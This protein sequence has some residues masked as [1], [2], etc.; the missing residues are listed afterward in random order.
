MGR[1]AEVL[2][3]GGM[4]KEAAVEWRW[5]KHMQALLAWFRSLFGRRGGGWA[6]Q[7]EKYWKPLSSRDPGRRLAFRAREPGDITAREELTKEYGGAPQLAN[8]VRAAEA[9]RRATGIVPMQ[10]LRSLDR[11]IRSRELGR[12]K[13]F[14]AK[15]VGIGGYYKPDEETLTTTRQARQFS[16]VVPHELRHAMQNTP[17]VKQTPE[18]YQPL[19]GG[20]KLEISEAQLQADPGD[21]KNMTLS[22]NERDYQGIPDR[23]RG[24]IT[25]ATLNVPNRAVGMQHERVLKYLASGKE[26]EAYLGNARAWGAAQGM[27]V[28]ADPRRGRQEARRVLESMMQAKPA[29]MPWL[30]ALRALDPSSRDAALDELSNMMPA[31][32]QAVPA[33]DYGKYASLRS[34]G[35]LAALAITLRRNQ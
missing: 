35:A 34:Q 1:L 3:D 2:V 22:G 10:E 29:G 7:P 33:A 19:L 8:A 24:A 23:F 12:I 20:P 18:S 25:G 5:R 26:L 16:F 27:E 15:L 32:V 28:P 30:D 9:Y 31:V 17:G 13:S 6:A 4:T 14:L 11:P 21:P